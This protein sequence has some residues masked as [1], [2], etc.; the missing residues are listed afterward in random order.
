MAKTKDLIKVMGEITLRGVHFK[1]EN[2][3]VFSKFCI[4]LGSNFL[5]FI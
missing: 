5:N 3:F 4:I 1:Q 2:A